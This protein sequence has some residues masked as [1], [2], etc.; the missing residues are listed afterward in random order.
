MEHVQHSNIISERC[1]KVICILSNS[2]F[3]DNQN[4]HDIDLIMS[5]YSRTRKMLLLPIIYTRGHIHNLPASLEGKLQGS[6]KIYCLK[7]RPEQN[8][9][10]NFWEK[11]IRDFEN[12]DLIAKLSSK[13]DALK[14]MNYEGN[15]L[16]QEAAN[17][18]P[19]NEPMAFENNQ[20]KIIK[21]LRNLI[22]RTSA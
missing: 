3:E 16:V 1:K 9:F 8:D 6:M 2:F 15:Q 14:A 18:P 17:V 19:T 5:H 22:L 12:P 21:F 7:Y 13:P 20:Q 10:V 4:L 11:L